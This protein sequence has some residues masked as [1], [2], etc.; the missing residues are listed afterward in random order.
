MKGEAYTKKDEACT[1]RGKVCT[2]I[3]LD[4]PNPTLGRLFEDESTWKSVIHLDGCRRCAGLVDM[5]YWRHL[6]EVIAKMNWPR[7]QPISMLLKD[8][9]T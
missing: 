3:G 4:L 2:K 6:W 1:I 9:W 5:E 8:F 7:E